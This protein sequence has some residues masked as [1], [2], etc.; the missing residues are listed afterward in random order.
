MPPAYPVPPTGP[1]PPY[2]PPPAGQF[3]GDQSQP[4]AAAQAARPAAPGAQPPGQW[5]LG[6]D[7]GVSGVLPDAGL[8]ATWRPYRWLHGQLGFGYNII[9]PG[10]RTGI[11]AINPWY[12]PISLTGEAGHYFNGNANSAVS[13][14]TG[15]GSDVAILRAVGY[16]Y[17]NLLAGIT[18]GG[19]HFVFYFRAGMTYMRATINNFQESASKLAGSSMEASNPQLTYHGPT[20]KFGM[21]VFY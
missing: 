18:S 1:P 11:T 6:L 9:S 5:G 17:A 14:L 21:I 15:Q 12:F 10:I 19:Q 2:P 4:A 16:D 3:R 8:L 20:L 13:S 7:L